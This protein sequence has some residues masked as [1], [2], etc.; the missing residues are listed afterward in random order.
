MWTVH[1][2]M[3]NVKSVLYNVQ[4]IISAVSILLVCHHGLQV[5]KD[6]L[7]NWSIFFVSSCSDSCIHSLLLKFYHVPTQSNTQYKPLTT[8][9]QHRPTTCLTTYDCF[10]CPGNFYV[11]DMTF[12]RE[13][14]QKLRRWQKMWLY[15]YSA[16][17]AFALKPTLCL[18]N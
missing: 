18:N 3:Y 5:F 9:H 11:V 13:P 10:K 12:P 14:T 6:L 17:V 4:D 8:W 16:Q 1:V 7:L 2:R 15:R